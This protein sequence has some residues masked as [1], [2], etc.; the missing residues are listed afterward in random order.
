MTKFKLTVLAAA[1]LAANN[2]Y[3]ADP[4][5]GSVYD[6]S[7]IPQAVQGQNFAVRID[8]VTG[9]VLDFYQAGLVGD[10]QAPAAV[11]VSNP[12]KLTGTT[13]LEKTTYTGQSAIDVL[14]PIG[15][16][17]LANQLQL[18]EDYLKEQLLND[19]T[20]HV[21]AAGHI[22]AIEENHHLDAANAPT[23]PST[24]AEGSTSNYVGNPATL[25]IASFTGD[26]TALHSRPSANRI[27]WLD[28]NGVSA[29]P[30]ASV[31]NG[32]LTK[33][34]IASSFVLANGQPDHQ[35]RYTVWAAVA[36]AYAAFD[37]D[38]TTDSSVASTIARQTDAQVKYGTHILI[39]DS[40][41]ST[42]NLCSACGGIAQIN[43]L[44]YNTASTGYDWS[45][46]FA[47]TM[48]VADSPKYVGDVAVHEA[49]H[50]FGLLHDGIK[51]SAG[52]TTAAY[53]YGHNA[54]DGHVY[55]APV[56]GAGYYSQT[57]QF[58]N[59][60]YPGANNQQNDLTYIQGVGRVGLI[61]DI[62]GDTPATA[63]SLN[64]TTFDG[65]KQNVAS[66]G[67][68]ESND[69][70][71]VYSFTTIT[72]G[73]VK[74]DANYISETLVP[75][76]KLLDSNG[77]VIATGGD[78]YDPT[79]HIN[80]TVAKGTYY[81]VVAP[82]GISNVS[83]DAGYAIEAN[84]GHYNITGFYTN[85]VATV[86]NPVTPP[87]VVT[88]VTPPVVTP[89]TPPKPVPPPTP[90]PT[91]VAPTAK[92]NLTNAGGYIPLNV[93]LS[94]AASIIGSGSS[95]TYT[96]DFGDG[97]AKMTNSASAAVNHTYV[98]TGTFKP[99][100]MVTNQY[101]LTSTTQGTVTTSAPPAAHAVHVTKITM[102]ISKVLYNKV[103]YSRATVCANVVD[104][105]IQKVAGA[106]LNGYFSGN[107]SNVVLPASTTANNFA[108]VANNSSN[109]TC[110]NSNYYSSTTKGTLSFISTGLTPPK[111]YIY[112]SVADNM[113]SAYYNR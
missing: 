104:E 44:Y 3:T 37:I 39:T 33:T 93:S 10:G 76:L 19:P 66:P 60:T 70:I 48:Y 91:Y 67:M 81:V 26:S 32:F 73:A 16:T 50:T 95:L 53:D 22:I 2:A 72:G 24:V 5:V 6:S 45:V 79:A 97:S 25:A 65:I 29:L 61:K 105:N 58:S 86:V 92:L 14:G 109:L 84:V 103:W 38:V 30:T 31:W 17:N 88:P 1:L 9:K 51:N 42:L 96:W 57:V 55:W 11:S 99:V 98:N 68:I 62:I 46:A 49:G 36:E 27:I 64:P 74:F 23:S 94:A 21:D 90:T 80:A 7:N 52:A 69:D 40:N 43:G 47:F 35:S 83:T 108:S 63:S 54:P 113:V 77:N 106:V 101:G 41:P 34:P 8:P 12:D 102:T 82:R 85:G 20:L 15:I 87:P 89:V 18:S 110:G 71:D 107:I 13:E 78:N 56:M 75:G 28:F 4:L 112:N 100:L 111:G 59:G